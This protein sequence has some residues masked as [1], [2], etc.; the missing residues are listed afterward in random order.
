MIKPHELRPM[1]E[2]EIRQRIKD[3]LEALDKIKFQKAVGGEVKNPVQVRFLRKEIAKMRTILHER[4]LEAAKKE[5]TAGS[6]ES[7]VA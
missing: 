6:N 3:N 1:S 4:E 2:K 5:P 7:E